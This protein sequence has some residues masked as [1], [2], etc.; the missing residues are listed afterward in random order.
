MKA[1]YFAAAN[2]RL[3]HGDNRL[4]RESATHTVEGDL[5]LCGHGL[6]ASERI[7][8][9]LGYAPGPLICRVELGGAILRGGDKVCASSRTYLRVLPRA[10]SEAVLREFARKAALRVV[11]LWNAPPVVVKWLKTGNPSLRAQAY[12]AARANA[13]A[14]GAYDAY[15]NAAA[16]AYANDA[17]VNAAARA[18]SRAY[19]VANAA[20]AA[21][22]A[23]NAAANAAASAA[24]YVYVQ[25]LRQVERSWQERTL[26]RLV[27][28]ALRETR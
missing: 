12:I 2:R 21:N 8:D 9:A 15:V 11:H 25:T 16:N 27:N 17:A 26:T 20:Y 10:K 24:A 18:Y 23:A 19:A 7:T 4:V 1:W 13:Y 6:H 22:T 14:D 28:K 5:E 3:R